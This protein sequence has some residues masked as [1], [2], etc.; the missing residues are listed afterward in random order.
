MGHRNC[1]EFGLMGL[2]SETIN[3]IRADWEAAQYGGKSDI[4]K[5][6][7]KSLGLSYCMIYGKLGIGRQ[8]QAGKRKIDNIE[9][10]AN[11]VAMIK[12]KPPERVGEIATDQA[13][14]IAIDNGLIPESMNNK[15]ST[16]N[17]INR[18]NG[19]N[20]RQRRIQRFQAE[21]PNELHHIDASSSKSFYIHRETDDGDYI[22]RLH[23]GEQGYKNKPV[24]I[25]KRPWVYGLTDDHSGFVVARYIA[26]DGEN[27]NDNLEF[28]EWAWA[29]NDDKVLF[30][31][32]DKIKGDLGPMMRGH[33]FKDFVARLGVE[34]DPSEPGN[35]EAHGKIERT[36]RTQW[37][38][39]ERSYFVQADWKKFEISLSELNRQFLNYLEEYNDR[40][41]RYETEISR[42]QAWQRISLLGGAVE[43]PENALKTI[44][45]RHKRVVGADGC[46][47]LNGVTYEVKGL[48]D[49]RVVVY[50]GVFEDKLIVQDQRTGIK[51]EVED[52]APNPLGKFTAHEETPHQIAAKEAQALE[53]T[54]RLYESPKDR[55]NVAQLPTRTKEVRQIE[56]PLDV[57]A[58]PSIDEAMRDFIIFSGVR[59]DKENREAVKQRIIEIGLS[60]HK[61]RN[62]ALKVQAAWEKRRCANE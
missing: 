49:A 12:K 25:R 46:F 59:L 36:W 34:I 10:I 3:L 2:S 54:S 1:S 44:A 62:L 28:L 23:V 5:K 40:S 60:R 33:E 61:V 24:P 43:I 9:D 6:W 19:L 16:I 50:K 51:Y 7:A 17:R 13:I 35:K 48:H 31:L 37:D 38:R 57:D 15:V 41:H 55:G 47:S 18:E 39:F 22:L 27:A 8:R 26:A 32:P 30:G 14:C 52:F 21:R 58:Y 29:K 20:K 42:R 45:E 56:N 4:I 53:V 11:T